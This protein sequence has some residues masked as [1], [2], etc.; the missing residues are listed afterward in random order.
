M[1]PDETLEL[2]RSGF[3]L[4][5]GP[6]TAKV[7]DRA[8][9]GWT[10]ATVLAAARA[11]RTGEALGDMAEA[12][13]A[14][15][16]PTEAVAAILDEAVVALGPSSRRGLAQVARLPLLDAGL[17]DLAAGEEGFFERSLSAGIPYTPARGPWW[18]LPGPVRDYLAT[19]SPLSADAM[20]LAAKE[21]GRRGELEWALQLLL[22]S[23]DAGEAASMLAATPPEV[24]ETMDALELGAVFDQLPSEAVD[25]H[26]N[27]L[28]V[29]ARAC[30]LATR[31]DQGAVLLERAGALAAR[32]GDSALE[33]AIAAEERLL[34][35]AQGRTDPREYWRVTLLRA[36]AAF[37]RGEDR[38]AGA[39]AARACEEAARLGQPQL[40]LVRE[41]AVTE[42][43]L[44]LA[45]ETG[46]PAPLALQAS[47]LPRSLAVLGRFELTEAG[48]PVTLGAGQEAQLLKY[49]A[50]SG[51]QVHAEQAIETIWP[52]GGRDAGRNRLRTVLNRLR[53]LAGNVLVREG[54]MLVLDET[55]RVDVAEFF[56]E[57]RRAQALAATD[58]ALATAIARGAISRYRGDLLPED[59][60]EDWAEKQR[61][62]ARLALLDLLDLCATEAARRGD[63][64]GLRR[65][66]ERTTE[67]APYDD[68]RYLRAASTLLQQGRRGEALSVVHRARS[69][70]AEIG[71]DPP[72]PLLDLER[73]IVA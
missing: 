48:R 26:P 57:A 68:L 29:V 19:F 49:V 54:D 56:V 31:F 30:R 51:G 35:A 72:R 52:E 44:G 7:L 40:P 3:E 16:H 65:I 45:V 41:R 66:V 61:Q 15:G 59:R 10:A 8:T 2:C 5:I 60:Y 69:A 47:A 38:Q 50:V 12:A 14:P 34:A 71:L 70:F 4:K 64:D 25:A 9:G 67:F 53:A 18:D 62:R 73:S 46:Q 63:L 11:A 42:Q 33:R 6:H 55:V 43:L 37:R 39:L 13:I 23:G 20:R 24:V 1:T 27:V 21:Y 58:L 28:L 22:A 32:A 36:F 17:V